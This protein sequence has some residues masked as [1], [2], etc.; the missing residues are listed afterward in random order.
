MQ[1]FSTMVLPIDKFLIGQSPHVRDIVENARKYPV[2]FALELF[3]FVMMIVGAIVTCS[4]AY[5][6]GKIVGS[7]I[8]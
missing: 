4:W 6:F 2:P 5:D 7:T 8:G 1:L 3:A